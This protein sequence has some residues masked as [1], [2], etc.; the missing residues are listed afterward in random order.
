[1][2]AHRISQDMT[3][4]DVVHRYPDTEAVFRSRDKQAGECILCKALF[5]T[6]DEVARRYGLDREK[7]LVDLEQ[8]SGKERIK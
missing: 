2:N 6:I 5:E 1:V 8:A 7:L 4:L 3:L